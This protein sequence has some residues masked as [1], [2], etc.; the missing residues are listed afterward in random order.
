MRLTPELII[1]SRWLTITLDEFE[2]LLQRQLTII[3]MLGDSITAETRERM[4]KQLEGFRFQ[5]DIEQEEE[6]TQMEI[7]LL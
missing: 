4:A 3:E 2:E 5:Q 6:D 1:S 7:D